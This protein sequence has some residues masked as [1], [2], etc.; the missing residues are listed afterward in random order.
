M[1]IDKKS[2]KKL[3]PHLVKEL[4]GEENKIKIDSIR[5]DPAKAE[6]E[7]ISDGDEAML[8]EAKAALPDLF[9][10]YNPTIIDFIRRCDTPIQAE[11]II[12]YLL[13]RKEITAKQAAEIRKQ[14]KAEG[15]RSL[16][17]KKEEGYYFKESGLC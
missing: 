1:A 12:C 7:V 2:M 15:L 14:I 11:E 3:F 6:E 8:D 16:G 13:K 10:H 17:P 4:D 9:R 5:A